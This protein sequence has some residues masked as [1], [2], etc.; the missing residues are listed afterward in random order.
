MLHQAQPQAQRR[1]LV[2]PPL[3]RAIPAADH[4][5]DGAHLHAMGARIAHQLR[6]RIESHRLTVDEGC[7]KCRRLVV[8]EPGGAVYEEGE[9][10]GV[11]FRKAVLPEPQYLIEYLMS[12]ALGIAPLA[13]AI[14][15]LALE[16]FQAALALPGRHRA[17]Q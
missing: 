12:E 3:E 7:A 1:P 13:H 16:R 9:A 5:V 2:G 15:Q 4:R 11:G 17:A 8:L 6:R 10:R 14:D